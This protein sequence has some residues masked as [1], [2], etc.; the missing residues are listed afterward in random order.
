MLDSSDNDNVV[1]GAVFGKVHTSS[2]TLLPR[3]WL[4]MLRVAKMPVMNASY[5]YSAYD[6]GPAG[7]LAIHGRGFMF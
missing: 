3:N 2:S 6:T 7:M 1:S 5:Q 4:L